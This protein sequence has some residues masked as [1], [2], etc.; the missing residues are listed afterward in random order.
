MI[1]WLRHSGRSALVVAV[2]L[3]VMF[4]AF[5]LKYIVNDVVTTNVPPGQ[6]VWAGGVAWRLDSLEANQGYTDWTGDVQK[7]M[8]GATFVIAWLSYMQM[9][10]S[11]P[12][13]FSTWLQGDNRYWIHSIHT[14]PTTDSVDY[15][16]GPK[17]Q[18]VMLFEIPTSAL[19]EIKGITIS[20]GF[21]RRALL[22]G[23][24]TQR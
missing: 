13:C 22:E 3:S 2:A 7:P 20:T 18:V 17:G 14:M 6:V 9:G 4:A 21:L 16:H 15:C 19:P 10:D 8:E 1:E 23:N 24:V 5:W 12:T 11:E